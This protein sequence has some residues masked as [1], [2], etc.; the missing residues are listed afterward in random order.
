VNSSWGFEALIWP[1]WRAG[2]VWGLVAWRWLAT[3]GAFALLW[4]TA[5]RMGARGLGALLVVAL[6]AVVYRPR[7]NIRPESLAGVLLAL[8][9][10][11]LEGRRR[12]AA[13]RIAWLPAVAWA[14]ANAHVTYYFGLAVAGVYL[15]DAIV[16]PP[17]ERAAGPPVRPLALAVLASIAVSLLNPFG[18]RALWQPF[19]FFLHQRSEPIYRTILELLPLD[20]K[21]YWGQGLPLI[22][23]GWA[24][25]LLWRWRRL[26]LDLAEIVLC[27]GFTLVAFSA[28]RFVGFYALVALPFL[29]RDL[30]AWLASRRWRL[31]PAPWAAAG[32][33]CVACVAAGIHDWTQPFPRWGLGLD[34]S[35]RPAAACD[36]IERHGVR[37]RAFN[38]FHFGG[39]L[40][41]RFWPQRDRLPFMDIHQA[42][43][44]QDRDL[45]AFVQVDR[46]AWVELDRRHRFDYA[47][48]VRSQGPDERLL[49]WI[50]ADSTWALVFADDE[51]VLYVRRGGSLEP[52]RATGTW[53]RAARAAP[54]WARPAR[55]TRR[56]AARSRPSW[57][58]RSAPRRE[59]RRRAPNWP[60][61]C[62]WTAGTPRRAN[63]WSGR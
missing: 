48:L 9:L 3:F 45:Y 26:G 57:N 20:L 30:E 18:W 8:E 10:W 16:R 11:I 19:D 22:M 50:E 46:G 40:L 13:D 33:T 44:R 36:F 53:W 41:W 54:S 32:L 2:G 29:A 37:G 34:P 55:G 24:A 28:R 27:A 61:C 21:D 23:A 42:G 6:C 14:W 7:T 12:G 31:R 15:L 17:R 60:T 38:P 1:F 51:A 63:S 35:G 5:R 59:T 25:L 49:D 58:G 4:A 62:C 47:L 39:Y 43:T 56:C 52:V